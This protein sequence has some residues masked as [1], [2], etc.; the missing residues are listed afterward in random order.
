MRRLIACPR[1][2]HVSRPACS[3]F[4]GLGLAFALTAGGLSTAS[5]ADTIGGAAKP[6]GQS[7]AGGAAGRD[8]RFRKLVVNSRLSGHFTVDGA[9]TDKLRKEDYVITT[10]TKFGSGDLWLLAARIRYND[11]DLT[12]PVPVQVKWAGDT[13]VITLDKVGIPGLGTFSA[14][15]VL[16]EGRYAGTW[17]H[18]DKGGHLFGTIRPA[19]DEPGVSQKP[20][21]SP[22]TPATDTPAEK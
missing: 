9:D 6:V 21:P 16:D 13:P 17:S 7:E 15:V 14:R 18:D 3:L 12:V 19:V 10:A 8:D 5:A 4:A 11:V 20:E 22:K 2:L 1:S